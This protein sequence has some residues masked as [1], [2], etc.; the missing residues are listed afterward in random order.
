MDAKNWNNSH[1]FRSDLIPERNHISG[2]FCVRTRLKLAYVSHDVS[3]GPTGQRKKEGKA[4]CGG[5]GRSWAAAGP[6]C[7]AHARG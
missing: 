4:G 7:A 6:L 2:D 1:K 3:A 5:L